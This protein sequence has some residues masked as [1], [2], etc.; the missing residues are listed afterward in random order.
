MILIVPDNRQLVDKLLHR[1]IL[2]CKRARARV[3][4]L[5]SRL[6]PFDHNQLL[7]VQTYSG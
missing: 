7:L 6:I 5:V 3:A 2:L 1:S 4:R